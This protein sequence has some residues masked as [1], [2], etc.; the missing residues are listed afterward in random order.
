MDKKTLSNYGWIVI[1]TLV[2][3]V[4]I[5]FAT[6]FGSYIEVSVK[7]ITFSFMEANDN[8][9]NEDNIKNSGN[10]W[11]DKFLSNCRHKNT[12]IKNV[13]QTT[14]TTDGYSGDEICNNCGEKIKEGQNEIKY[15]HPKTELRN[16][17]QTYTGDLFCVLCDTLLQRGKN[18]GTITNETTVSLG[19]YKYT[20]YES[21]DGWR[22]TLVASR[23][24]T[25]YSPIMPS[26]AGKDIKVVASLFSS[27][28]N[29]LTSPYIPDSVTS[30]Y[31]TFQGC[32]SLKTITNFPKN[33]T[34][35]Q[36]M[37]YNATSLEEIPS[38]EHCKQLTDTYRAFYNC[39]NLKSY[40]N[41]TEEIGCFKNYKLPDTITNMY[42]MFSCCTSLK[43]P[44]QF[45]TSATDVM[46]AYDSCIFLNDVS[47]LTIPSGA[48]ELDGL[49][50]DCTSLSDATGLYMGP[51]VT[52]LSNTFSGCTSLTKAYVPESATNLYH[53]FSDIC[54]TSPSTI[55]V[56]LPCDRT[57]VFYNW[58][59]R[60][61]DVVGRAYYH[62]STCD[63]SCGT[64][65][66]FE[67]FPQR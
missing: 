31:S 63:G 28:E 6:P 40:E 27:C 32:T 19:D 17:T 23:T 60:Y 67:T 14:C 66:T 39:Q 58:N 65:A 33:L 4:M 25:A 13:I 24:K 5:A 1:L 47:Y 2:L 9:V 59:G 36:N 30:M 11:D 8:A 64:S 57:N 37:C 45:P 46:F 7:N 51:N 10:E 16:V 54:M 62:K 41:S 49:F 61:G 12:S 42:G 22:V 26:I 50:S 15:N 53:T 43:K 48:N 18:I 3:S 34:T 21:Y 44:P 52:S 38:M 20:Y 55:T 56:F 35:I 29:M